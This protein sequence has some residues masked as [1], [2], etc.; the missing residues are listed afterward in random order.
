MIT[1]SPNSSV[2]T[3]TTQ[4]REALLTLSLPPQ[5][6]FGAALPVGTPE[7]ALLAFLADTAGHIAERDRLLDALFGGRSDD[8]TPLRAIRM[9]IPRR[10][11]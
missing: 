8:S 1:Y 10:R 2:Q 11:R 5:P 9:P 3:E 7:P 6:E 4:T